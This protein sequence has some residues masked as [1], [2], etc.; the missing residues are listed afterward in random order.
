MRLGQVPRLMTNTTS[1]LT[2]Q[3]INNMSSTS[4]QTNNCPTREHVLLPIQLIKHVML[5]AG[6]MLGTPNT[7]A[8]LF[9]QDR[10][11]SVRVSCY[12]GR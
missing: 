3:Q 10:G 11:V 12:N 5:L 6:E 7:A 9:M 4:N 1:I 2:G 8:P